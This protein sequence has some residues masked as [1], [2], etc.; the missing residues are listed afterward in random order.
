MN[1]KIIIA[2]HKEYEMPMDPMYLPVQVGA[3]GKPSIGVMPGTDPEDNVG[4]QRDDTGDNIS[5]KNPYYCE[6]TGLYWAWKNLDA[7]A[8]GLVHYRRLFREMPRRPR[9]NRSPQQCVLTEEQAQNLLQSHDMIVT[10]KRNYVIETLYSHYAH[11]HDSRHLDLAREIL[12]EKYPQYLT[13][14]DQ[15]YGRRWGYMYNMCVMKR[16]DLDVYCTWL[17]DILGEME[18]RLPG[19]I[20]MQSLSDFDKRLYG[21]VSEI[22]LNVWV[23]KRVQDGMTLTEVPVLYMEPVNLA[24]KGT[25]FLKAKFLGKKYSQ[26]R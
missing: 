7:E 11:T 19:I 10:N 4:Y 26:S 16:T 24:A 25:A 21:R 1:I 8:I 5:I 20:D 2:A 6:L 14:C 15:V 22:L 18:E 13:A 17:F 23:E 3:A 12:A 9:Q